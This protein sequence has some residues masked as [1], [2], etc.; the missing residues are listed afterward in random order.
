MGT[1]HWI[2]DLCSVY[3]DFGGRGIG[4]E[5]K[6]MYDARLSFE[7][8]S[9][10]ISIYT[11]FQAGNLDPINWSQKFMVA[12]LGN[13]NFM[14]SFLGLATISFFVR[15]F[16][17]K[18]GITG[19]L[20]FGFFTLLNLWLIWISNSIQGLG[21]F[22]AGVSIALAF[23]LRENMGLGTACVFV[24]IAT[25]VGGSVFAGTL[26]M[27][28]FSHIKQETV[29]FRLDYWA[30]GLRMLKDN[31]LNGVGID[32][33]GDFYTQYRDLEA[34]TRTGPQRVTNTAHNIFLDVASGSGI[35]AGL[36]FAAIFIL[37]FY[38]I[39]NLFTKGIY[40]SS[41]VT[42]SSFFFGFL[43]FC[44]ISINQIGVGV[45][46]F[47]FMGMIIGI[48]SNAVKEDP[49]SENSVIRRNGNRMKLQNSLHLTRNFTLSQLTL[50]MV[51]SFACFVSAF[52]PN[53]I[54]GQMLRAVQT[55]DFLRMERLSSENVSAIYHRSKYLSLA[56]E[57]GRE[58]EALEFA[59]FEVVRSERNEFAWRI[60]AFKSTEGGI[61]EHGQSRR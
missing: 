38:K 59:R 49:S 25:I 58:T 37:A 34:V 42:Y 8:L 33:Y 13:V 61:R 53:L 27:G 40:N 17:D 18:V 26:G 35:F 12:T 50:S 60:I 47:I 48:P 16:W 4:V 51:I 2:P 46:G 19:F 28:P 32:S 24:S 7:R 57:A 30:A 15:L 5:S 41:Q 54:D 39:L 56:L 36:A 6:Y 43:V 10:F 14:S 52:I 1:L 55:R 22:L 23:K 45:W 21:I 44:L 29:I 11:L 31:W 9:Y 20:H 3:S